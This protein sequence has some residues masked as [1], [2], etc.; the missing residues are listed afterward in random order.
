MKK[1]KERVCVEGGESRGHS[2]FYQK[3]FD[4]FADDIHIHV[5]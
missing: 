5:D 3:R 4:R 2:L 1:N